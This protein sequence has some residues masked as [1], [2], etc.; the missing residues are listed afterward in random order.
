[1]EGLNENQIRIVFFELKLQL[2]GTKNG[3]LWNVI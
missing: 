3:A 2:G 1:M